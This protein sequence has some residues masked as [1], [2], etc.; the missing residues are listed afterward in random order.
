[1]DAKVR[2]V[3]GIDAMQMPPRYHAPI[4]DSRVTLSTLIASHHSHF[5]QHTNRQPTDSPQTAH[6][7]AKHKAK[8]NTNTPRNT[9]RSLIIIAVAP[10]HSYYDMNLI[11][12]DHRHLIIDTMPSHAPPRAI[13]NHRIAHN[14]HRSPTPTSF[15]SITVI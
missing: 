11:H 8:E 13:H 6:S 2:K 3:V 1:M 10:A 5:M 14:D 15:I 4:T 12:P 9:V 7:K